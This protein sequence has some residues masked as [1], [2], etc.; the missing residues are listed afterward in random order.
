MSYSQII[1]SSNVVCRRRLRLQQLTS[2]LNKEELI[3]AIV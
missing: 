2:T 1:A 3:E